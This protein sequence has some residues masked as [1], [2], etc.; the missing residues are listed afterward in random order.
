MS[1]AARRITP[2]DVMSLE[3]YARVRRDWRREVIALKRDRR[4][5]VGPDA[6]LYFENYRTHA[7]WK[8]LAES[9]L[10]EPANAQ[11]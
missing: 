3:D 2:A 5:A 7:T 11:A 6:T 10:G 4:L 8:Q 9:L 1:Q